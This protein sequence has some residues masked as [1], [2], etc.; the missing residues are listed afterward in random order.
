MHEPLTRPSSRGIS[1]RLVLGS[2]AAIAF[3]VAGG[4]VPATA[5]ATTPGRH[6]ARR[7]ALSFLDA[8]MDAYP[9]FGPTRLAQSYADQSGLFSTA[10]VY[11]NAL[12]VLAHLAD[13]I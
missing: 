4:A 6:P 7:R 10:F 11:D 1:R 9:A 8:A 13:Q 5:E 12:A 2:G 3:A